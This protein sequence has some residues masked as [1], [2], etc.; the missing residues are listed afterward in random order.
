MNYLFCATEGDVVRWS[1]EAHGDRRN[2]KSS[3]NDF[4]LFFGQRKDELMKKNIADKQ[5]SLPK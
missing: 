2:V 4:L 3:L 1:G 5:F